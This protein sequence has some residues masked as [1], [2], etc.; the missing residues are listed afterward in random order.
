MALSESNRTALTYV[1]ESTYGTTP[2]N[3]SSWETIRSTGE[4]PAFGAAPQT[5]VSNEIRSDRQVSDLVLVSTQVQGGFNF[6]F[7]DDTY[8]T[9]LE[10]ALCGTWTSDVL[11][12]G[13]T[14]R[15]FTVSKQFTDMD[16]G[17]SPAETDWI[18]TTGQRIGTMTLD[19]VFGQIVTGSFGFQGNGVST[20]TTSLVGSGSVAAATTTDIM[21]SADFSTL[22]IDTVTA[23][24]YIRRI[25]LN[26]NNNLRPIEAL[27][28]AAPINQGYGRS[29]LTGTIE[30]Y[31]QNLSTFYAKLLNS[32]A[33]ELE[34]QVD[35]GTNKYVFNLPK[36]K[37]QDGD[38]IAS[39]I[40]QD[41]MLTMNFTA[42]YNSSDASQIVI[43]RGTV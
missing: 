12:A 10:A 26:L 9:F 11:K 17:V 30:M 3:S 29:N 2:P 32:T 18:H 24:E 28:Y 37:F 36:I 13:T 20:S 6:E 19:F 7:S 33:V 41:V 34:W 5:I 25:A 38:P 21:S 39:G 1:A 22:K 27:G 14:K 16:D 35:D 43:T 40:D 23:T 4:N 42:L 15:S 31:V 8:D